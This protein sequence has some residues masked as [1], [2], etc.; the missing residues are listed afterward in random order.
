MTRKLIG[1]N[2]TLTTAKVMPDVVS[3]MHYDLGYFDDETGGL[4]PIQK[5]VYAERVTCLRRGSPT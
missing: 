3:F 1:Q 4:E 2:C 5:P